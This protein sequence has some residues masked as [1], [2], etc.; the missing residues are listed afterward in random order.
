MNKVSV[1]AFIT[2]L[3][4]AG[5]IG[6]FAAG[7]G[8]SSK[9][10]TLTVAASQNWVK[11]IDR[12]IAEDFKAKTGITIDFQVNPD[13]QYLQIL[14]TKLNTGEAP[15]IFMW[16]AGLR[17]LELPLDKLLD[18]SNE[19]WAAREK[20]WAKATT[21]FDGKLLALNTWSIDGWGFVY[22]DQIFDKYNLEAPKTY[23]ELL[24]VCS[25]LDANGIIPIYE[26]PSDLWHTQ[27]FMTE[28]AAQAKERDP[29]LYDKLNTNQLK[30]A[31][32]E[33]F[34]TCLTQIKELAD[35]GYF[36]ENYMSDSW[37]RATEALGTGKYA[38]FLGYT[39]W[40]MEVVR[41]YPDAGAENFKMFPS[42]LGAQ[43]EATVF[44]TSAG[45]IVQIAMKDGENVDAVKQWLKYKTQ[46]DVL[47]K[48]YAMRDDLGNPSFPEVDKKPTAGLASMTEMV[49]GN[50]KPDGATGILFWDQMGNGAEV[51][52]LLVGAATVD[53]VLANIDDKRGK[54][55]K[56]AGIE[57]F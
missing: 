25:V 53:E 47:N 11:D 8:E 38:M 51:Q 13:D 16:A 20:E 56:A 28:I 3:F 46:P 4:M 48:F 14:K 32:V 9:P 24:Q 34:R 45:G 22:N 1:F 35:K 18:L 21:T 55:A 33:E 19:P 15:D 2:I 52:S 27:L 29:S 36:G 39:S 12:E 10:V 43:G 41:D 54:T 44:G 5:A 23:A 57:G 40:Q 50:F 26:L 31:D 37:T 42:P 7:G 17:M 30:F 49:D 6:L